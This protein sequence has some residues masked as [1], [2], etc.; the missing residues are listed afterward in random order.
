MHAPLMGSL[1]D[2]DSC[3]KSP[4]LTRKILVHPASHGYEY[5]F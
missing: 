1:H 4:C 3:G 2:M 5:K